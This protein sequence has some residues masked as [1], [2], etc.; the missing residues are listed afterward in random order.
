MPQIDF[1]KPMTFLNTLEPFAL[2]LNCAM[3][4]LRNEAQFHDNG[5]PTVLDAANLLAA[6]LEDAHTEAVALSNQLERD[7]LHKTSQ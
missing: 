6:M 1:S 4:A 7:I 2:A 5:D 3:V